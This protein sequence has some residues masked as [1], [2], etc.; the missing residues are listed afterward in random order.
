MKDI[1]KFLGEVKLEMSRVVWPK[2]DEF[3][4]STIIVVFLVAVLSLYLG[5]VD[6]GI[7]RLMKYIMKYFGA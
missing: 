2:Y 5:V 3:V 6:L 4:G 7:D 1:G